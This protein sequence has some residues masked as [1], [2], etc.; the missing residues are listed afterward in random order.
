MNDAA[1]SVP[2][3]EYELETVSQTRLVF[4]L[5]SLNQFLLLLQGWTLDSRIAWEKFKEKCL[6]RAAQLLVIVGAVWFIFSL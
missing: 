6:M 2:M 1:M 5:F 3:G 4:S